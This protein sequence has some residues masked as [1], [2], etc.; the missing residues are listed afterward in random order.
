MRSAA[1]FTLLEV[2]LASTI[3]S[4]GAIGVVGS[5][6]AA[7]R[8]VIEA[9][10]LTLAAEIA[11]ARLIETCASVSAGLSPLAL[12]GDEGDVEW[13]AEVQEPDANVAL[14]TVRVTWVHRG[15]SRSFE[16]REAVFVLQTEGE[17]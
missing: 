13:A 9:D 16:L 14:V 2:V 11:E 5:I 6:G 4:V 15:E 7:L 12:S 3:L 8:S 17:S 10:R 1:A